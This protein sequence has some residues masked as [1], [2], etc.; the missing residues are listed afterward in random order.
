MVMLVEMKGAIK[1][2]RKRRGGVSVIKI[3]NFELS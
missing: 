3:K 1:E 2:G